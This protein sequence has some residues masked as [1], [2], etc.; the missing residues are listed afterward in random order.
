MSLTGSITAFYGV[1]NLH[2]AVN[3]Y[4]IRKKVLS[5]KVI[6]KVIQNKGKEQNHSTG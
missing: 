1:K 3:V 2:S 4:P 5:L 6:S